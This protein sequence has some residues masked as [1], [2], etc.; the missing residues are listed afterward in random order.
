MQKLA[1]QNVQN[2][3]FH[4]S[5]TKIRI[6]ASLSTAMDRSQAAVATAVNTARLPATGPRLQQH[7]AQ[8]RR[9][10]SA[11]T[12]TSTQECSGEGAC[13]LKLCSVSSYYTYMATIYDF[14]KNHI[15]HLHPS[16]SWDRSLSNWH[17]RILWVLHIQPG[18][19]SSVVH[20]LR[21]NSPACILDTAHCGPAKKNWSMPPDE[22]LCQHVVSSRCHSYKT[23][24][25]G[26][27]DILPIYPSK[28]SIQLKRWPIPHPPSPIL[29]PPRSQLVPTWLYIA[30]L[31]KGSLL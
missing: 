6:R 26:H 4:T 16:F 21:S 24:W 12:S 31:Q 9:Q 11:V 25:P 27:Q 1:Y 8:E 14:W 15:Y 18:Y 23:D 13:V 7:V 10:A 29:H 22:N 5:F 19:C 20:T 28:E 2:I 17:G 3:I 30:I